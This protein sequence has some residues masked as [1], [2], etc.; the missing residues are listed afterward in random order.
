MADCGNY[1]IATYIENR[2]KRKRKK[3]KKKGTRNK[4][5]KR[6]YYNVLITDKPLS[7]NPF[8]K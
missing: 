4:R 3:E 8:V 6:I 1:N 2:E 7:S 5:N